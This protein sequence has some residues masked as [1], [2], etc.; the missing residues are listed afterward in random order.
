MTRIGLIKEGKIPADNRV[1]LTPAQCKWIH[2]NF[3]S[4]KIVAQ[5]SAT[6]CFSDRE[7]LMAGVEVVEDLSGCD[8]LLGIKEVPV[9]ELIPEKIYLFFSHTKKKQP[10][11]QKLLQSILNKQITLIDYECLEHEDGQRIIGF[12]FFAGVVGAHNG[13][14]AYGNRTGS[15]QLERVYKQRSFRELIHTYFGLKLPN[16]KIVVTGSGRVAHGVVEIMNL[17]EVVE[18]EPDEFLAKNFSYPVYTQ[19]KGAELYEHKLNKNYSREHFHLH[20]EEYQCKFLPYASVSDILMNGV[21]WEK[22]VPRLFDRMDAQ[23]DNFK[24]RTIADIADDTGGSVP[25]N[26][27]DQTIDDPVYGV[28]RKTLEKTAPYLPSSI[29]IMAVGNLPNEL[30]RDASRYFGEQLIKYVLPD[31]LSSGSEILNKATIVKKGKL[32]K[33]FEYLRDYAKGK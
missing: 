11:N 5:S 24:I 20:P 19:L 28:D 6:R 9:E 13:M 25:I 4:V 30:P 29:D 10:R 14:M 23:N 18:V 16:V 8:I 22:D 7:F 31:L 21:Y 26:L 27:G 2:K 33:Y 15:Y 32:T 12:G 3:D 1:S 17:M